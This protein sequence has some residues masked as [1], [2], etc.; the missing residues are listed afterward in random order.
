MAERVGKEKISR[1]DG[2]LY[3]LGKDGYVWKTPMKTNPRG[4]K[5]KVG[6]E[7]V[8]RQE[9]YLYFIDKGGYVARAKMNRRGRR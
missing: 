5:S 6:S 1:E 3:F 2:Y 8:S 7:K 9:G 4:R